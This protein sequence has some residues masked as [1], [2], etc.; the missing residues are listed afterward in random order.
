[1]SPVGDD[2]VTMPG[3]SQ[4]CC[5]ECGRS[6]LARGR[7]R[8]CGQACRQRSYRARQTAPAVRDLADAG[9]RRGRDLTVYEC[10]RCGER[11]LGGQR[12]ESCGVFGTCLGYGLP[13]SACG[14]LL[15]L[16]ELLAQLGL[17]ELPAART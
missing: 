14:D 2:S 13:C 5:V 3:S 10:G 12:C 16:N 9:K 1:V 4:V 8:F 7:A 15:V 6:F 11:S 17:P